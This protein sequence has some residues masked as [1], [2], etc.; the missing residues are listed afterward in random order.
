M[1]TKLC[2]KVKILEI[3][4]HDGVEMQYRGHRFPS[5]R[6]ITVVWLLWYHLYL[7]T[8]QV[9]CMLRVAHQNGSF[10]FLRVLTSLLLGKLKSLLAKGIFAALTSMLPPPWPGPNNP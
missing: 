6:S 2:L 7:R 1:G 4:Q 8:P 10:S 5:F 3:G 9:A